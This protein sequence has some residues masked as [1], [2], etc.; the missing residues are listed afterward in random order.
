MVRYYGRPN[1]R[2]VRYADD[3]CVFIIRGSKQ[4]AEELKKE[5]GEF[6]LRECGLRLSEA[7]THITHVRDGFDFL[8]FRLEC[9]IGRRGKLIVKTKI[10]Q[11]AIPALKAKLDRE[12]R[13]VAQQVSISA[14][15]YRANLVLR[16]WAEYFRLG[17][18]YPKVAR[19]MDNY[20]FWS[21]VKAICRKSDIPTGKCLK[22]H[23]LKGTIHY[24]RME[25]L[26]KL[27]GKSVLLNVPSPAPYVPDG[28]NAYEQ[29]VEEERDAKLLKLQERSRPG[30]RDLK[31]AQL[32]RDKHRC[33]NCGRQV[34]HR[35]SHLDHIRPVRAFATFE[36]SNAED[37]LQTLCWECHW[38]KT[39]QN[40][41]A[42]N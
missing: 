16:G 22:Q 42:D 6:L 4:L 25:F 28:V 41:E 10:G 8:G 36:A 2:F 3:W 27:S 34:T 20:A 29:D 13:Y 23:Y 5:I 7:K 37:N 19:A 39:H 38:Q 1:Y 30:T 33:R 15:I 40:R 18:D 21:M 14:R 26:G 12:I 24:Q 17:H 32:R 11:K 9:G 35:T 31:L